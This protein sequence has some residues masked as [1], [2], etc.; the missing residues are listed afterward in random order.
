MKRFGLGMVLLALVMTLWSP[1]ASA[2]DMCSTPVA[3]G[4]GAFSG[5]KDPNYESCAYKGIPYAQPP[6]GDLRLAR[7]L[8]PASHQGVVQAVNFGPVCIQNH[9][10]HMSEDCLYLN[11]W[12]PAKPGVFP[13]MV[14]VHG[15]S[16]TAGSG[17]FDLYHGGNL[18]S[19]EDMVVVTINYRLGSLGY[20][21]LPE[22][23]AEDKDHSTGNMGIL[24]QI[25]ALEW[26]RDNIAG[27]G[28]DPNN[29]TVAGQSAGAMSVCVLLASP[30]A[31][32]LF[33]RAMMMSGPC[34]LF[35]NEEAGFKKGREF[36]KSIGCK[37]PEVVKCLLRLPASAY[38]Q[39]IPN[40]M[41]SGGTAWSPVVD[42]SVLKA[43]PVDAIQQGEYNKV[44]VII[45]T[46]HDELRAY[47]MSFYGLGLWP[48]GLVN[49]FM[50]FITGD[51]AKTILAM[52]D[53][54]EYRR[55][56]DVAFA[57]ANEMTFD[58][59]A[60]MMAQAMTGKNPVYWYRFD[61]HQTKMPHKVGAMHAIDIPFVF[62]SF[63]SNNKEFKQLASE[64]TVKNAMPLAYNM[65]KYVGNFART[66]NPNSEGVP[67]WQA[68]NL[69][70]KDRLYMDI[71]ISA[72]SLSENEVKRYEW[73]AAHP[74]KEVM[75]GKLI[76]S[77]G[78][79]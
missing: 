5:A 22:L 79:K 51:N 58:T 27:F 15:G 50:K 39:K 56:I 74:M 77:S 63:D 17:S 46:T 25:Q 18:S 21:A 62:G 14:W 23:K 54:K 9:G 65:M 64:K 4:Q 6:V 72:R 55:P 20:L 59:P 24:D 52:Y 75:T 41:F 19:R 31:K 7:P 78:A 71:P 13:V 26:V 29:V 43:M 32:G 3:T 48:K 12:R 1:T 42:G 67:K 38:A 34:R 35:S 33:Q 73:F 53:Y 47:A 66:G 10:D 61:W 40:D 37:G 44:P 11:I 57:F 68:Y 49:R 30:E 16:F 36:A 28:G 60:F 76:K 8:P 45:G 70:E 2:S 69:L